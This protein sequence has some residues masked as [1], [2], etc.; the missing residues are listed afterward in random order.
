MEEKGIRINKYL[1]EAGICSRRKADEYI[2]LGLVKV[3]GQPAEKGTRVVSGD[4]VQVKE[5]M[6]EIRNPKVVLAFYK[7]KGLV[8]STRGQGAETVLEYLHYPMPLYYVGRLDKDSEG[9]LLLTNDGAL[10][11]SICKAG[12]GHEKEYEVVVNKPI[13]PEFIRKMG[14]GVP[15]L[16]T[17]TRRCRVEQTGR[18]SFTIILTQGLNRQIRRMCEYCGYRVRKLKR[19][20]I[21]NIHLQGLEQGAYRELEGE[22]LQELQKRL[23]TP[24]AS[25]KNMRG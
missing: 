2:A 6:V 11:N 17:I 12:N 18:Q 19:V 16:D 4:Q 20:R 21:M 15:V 22:E 1:S 23:Q 14:N 10:A 3:N 7:P 25:R 24:G 9:L 13:T 8:C 5:Q